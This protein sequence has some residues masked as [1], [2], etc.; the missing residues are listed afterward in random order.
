MKRERPHW[1]DT[2]MFAALSSA[3]RSSCL[4]LQTGAVIVKDKRIIAS[5]YNGAPPG[6]ENCFSV[7]CRKDREKIEFDDKGKGICR[8]VHAEINAMNQ[9]SRQ[10]LIGASLYSVYYPC[11]SCAK[12]IVANGIHEVF[13]DKI[14]KEPDSL[15]LELFQEAG[16]HLKHYSMDIDRYFAMMKQIRG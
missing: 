8:G 6:I 3:T 12:S 11:S 2:F 5:G 7:G 1:H 16:V 13:Y 9:I 10:D 4:H 15:T 14:Y